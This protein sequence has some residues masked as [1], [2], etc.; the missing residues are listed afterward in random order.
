MNQNIKINDYEIKE[1]KITDKEYPKSLLT[2]QRPPEKL[3]A[4]GNLELLKLP[5]IA[6]VGSRNISD[7]G[8]RNCKNFASG[9]A[10]RNIPIVSGMAIGTDSVAHIEAVKIGSPTIAV[11]GAGFNYIYPTENLELM[12]RIIEKNGLII[13]ECEKDVDFNPK[14]FA[15]RNRIISGLALCVLVI[16]AAY[17]SGTSVTV[18]YAKKQGKKVFAL[19]GRLDL[20]NGIGVNNFIKEGAQMVTCVEE[21]INEYLEF[22]NT[23]L[24]KDKKTIP[25]VK[26]EYKEILDNLEDGKSIDE[27]L[28]ITK[29]D[30]Y[31][32]LEILINLENLGLIKQENG[33][34][35]KLI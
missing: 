15:K 30:K 18:N 19:P 5:S 16:E 31:E 34:G 9:F 14:K 29:K 33:I 17:R 3:Y 22:K 24:P 12:H 4:I 35:Y 28:W 26:K 2:I 32:L 23:I 21:I 11:L 27:L 8:I 1:I 25:K 20:T 7:Y 13:T 6:I 10:K